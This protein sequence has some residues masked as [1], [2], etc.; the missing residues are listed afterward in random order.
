MAKQATVIP[1]V[2]KLDDEGETSIDSLV[3]A[4][5]LVLADIGTR[6]SKTPPSALEGKTV[7]MMALNLDISKEEQRYPETLANTLQAIMDLGVIVAVTAGNYAFEHGEGFVSSGYPAVLA[8]SRLR[9]LIRVGAVDQNGIPP[10]WAQHGDVYACGVGYLCATQDSSTFRED[11]EGSSAALASFAGLVAYNLGLSSVP[12]N[13]GDDPTEYQ[14]I[15]KQYHMNGPGSWRRP[16][17][18]VKT[19]W[20]GLDGSASTYCAFN[21][22]K[23][24]VDV[25]DTCDQSSILSS[26]HYSSTHSETS[27]SSSTVP[28]TSTSSAAPVP[29]TPMGL[30]IVIYYSQETWCRKSGCLQTYYIYPGLSPWWICRG[31]IAEAPGSN[32]EIA[33]QLPLYAD[34]QNFTYS[35]ASDTAAGE[36]AGPGLSTPVK[37]VAAPSP[38]PSQ[39]C[40]PGDL[41][42]RAVGPIVVLPVTYTF[43]QWASCVWSQP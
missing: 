10:R 39:V 31:G 11:G 25:D 16:T 35:R 33:F 1:V 34:P 30:A 22:R 21:Q 8:E 18:R 15:V 12:Y 32:P 27:I 7:M 26:D 24:D 36:V 38:T 37:C 40:K 29:Y 13:F 19:V 23:R 14:S 41:D 3:T 9:S 17:S 4:A 5:Q 20:N 42:K 2:L 43:Y 28:P 6:R